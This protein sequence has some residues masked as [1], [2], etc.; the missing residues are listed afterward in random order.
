MRIFSNLFKSKPK[1]VY[2]TALGLFTLIYSKGNKNTWSINNSEILL[3]V[4]G[5]NIM[6][7]E[8]QLKFL[9][10]WESEIIKLNVKIN[11]R[12]VRE[13]KDADLPID[14]I[15]WT[16]KFKIVALD[17]ML[18]FEQEAYWNIT[19]E[20]L[21]EPFYHFILFIEGEKLTDFSID[22]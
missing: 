15:N 10:D 8:I 13:F 12:F 16:D 18:I 7:D 1:A 11:K 9:E 21:K 22:T 4:R 19:F 3:S 5:S 14:F 20:Q 6:P 2:N 17:V